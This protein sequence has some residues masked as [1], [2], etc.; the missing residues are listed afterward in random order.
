MLTFG[1]SAYLW[2]YAPERLMAA[3]SSVVRRLALVASV[4]ALFTATVWL[5]L[6]S[7][8]MADDWSAAVDPGAMGA[9]LTDTAF[10]HAWAVHLILAAMLVAVVVFGPSDRWA[11]TAV[12][13][14][15]LLASLGL[16]GHA[17]MQTG[18]E[19]VLHRGNH[20]VHLLAA[21]AWI[22]GLVPFVM[23]LGVYERSDIRREAITAMMRFSFAGQ[24]I[25]AAIVL[26]GAF[27]IALTSG[28]P[29]IPPNSPYRGLL[30]AKI[31]V[32]AIMIVAAVVNRY[33]LAPRL[34]PGARALAFLRA[35]S[36]AEIVLGCLVLALVS[37]FAL[38]DPV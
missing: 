13:S 2:L 29:P 30:I 4:V 31:A 26:T 16:V 15:A 10:G 21:G 38:L 37:V 12:A 33:V 11:P 19:G 34:K 22:G 3:L 6:E 35:T 24:F 23:C 17:A 14:G 28:H 27:N 32:V 7:A 5:A 20:A 18:A 25:V 36:T 9:V 1:S 8:S